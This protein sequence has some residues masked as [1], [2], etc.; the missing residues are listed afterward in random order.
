MIHEAG[1]PPAAI[2]GAASVRHEARG[3]S[4]SEPTHQIPGSSGPRIP[5]GTRPL[6]SVTP[7]AFAGRAEGVL[8]RPA[9]DSATQAPGRTTVGSREWL[10][11]Q[12]RQHWP[13]SRP[14]A[15]TLERLGRQPALETAVPTSDGPRS[16][17]TANAAR[18]A[19][20]ALIGR[21]PSAAELTDPGR[22]ALALGRSG[23]WLE[24]LLAQ[25]ATDP[26]WSSALKQ[27]LKAQLLALAEHLRLEG[28]RQ[29]NTP[30]ASRPE[31]PADPEPRRTDETAREVD[32]LVKQVVTKQIQSLDSPVGQTQWLLELP[33]RT[34]TGIQA[35][36]ADI[37]RE[38]SADDR[39][40]QAWSLTLRLDLPRIGPLHIWLTLRDERLNASLQ[41]AETAGAERIG[42]HLDELRARLEAGAIEVAGLHAG[43]RPLDRPAP[44]F[45]VPLVREQA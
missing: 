35:L 39:R 41:A 12:F 7:T 20:A 4:M 10:E 28:A 3:A 32:R 13:E 16:T 34:P 45:A 14:L 23:L 21:L 25:T 15:A 6:A 33:F 9:S 38:H 40:H 8:S 24:A 18:R 1:P 27:D 44:S 2:A 36:E 31:A 30:S 22:L 26:T 42:Q 11:Q 17:A 37:R 43:R 5:V 29:P 19:V